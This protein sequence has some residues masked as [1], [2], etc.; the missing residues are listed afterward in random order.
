[1]FIFAQMAAPQLPPLPAGPS[2]ENLRGPVELDS[3]FPLWQTALA[4]IAIGVVAAIFIS[5]LRRSRPAPA[6]TL[7]PYETALAELTAAE[8][9]TED[10]RFATLCAKAM[11]R[12]LELHF[13]LPAYS[14]TTAELGARLPLGSECADRLNR[15]LNH[16]D[17]VKFASRPLVAEDRVE[18][19]NTA[20]ELIETIEK[21][22]RGEASEK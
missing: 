5:L 20:K 14:M 16:C 10:G 21:L 11:R 3:G 2:L 15:L 19:S 8:Q 1:M 6:P 13:R 9:A 22:G 12:Y 7:S 4:L 18:I 17:Q